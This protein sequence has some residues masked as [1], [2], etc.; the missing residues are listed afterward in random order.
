M[1][2]VIEPSYITVIAW[3]RSIECVCGVI[4]VA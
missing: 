4:V 1:L 3:I 2:H